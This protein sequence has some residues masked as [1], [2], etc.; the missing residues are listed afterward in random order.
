VAQQP[1]KLLTI[2]LGQIRPLGN[3]WFVNRRG[4]TVL[5]EGLDIGHRLPSAVKL[6]PAAGAQPM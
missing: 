1:E 2:G 5:S 3:G 6:G 4:G